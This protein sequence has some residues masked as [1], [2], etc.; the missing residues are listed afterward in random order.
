MPISSPA[1]AEAFLAQAALMSNPAFQAGA[2][3]CILAVAAL[4]LLVRALHQRSALLAL[5]ALPAAVAAW[6][7]LG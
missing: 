1:S 7:A 4:C 3:G 2:F 6:A 5:A